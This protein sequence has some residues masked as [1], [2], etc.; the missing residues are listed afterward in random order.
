MDRCEICKNWVVGYSYENGSYEGKPKFWDGI[1][2]NCG[3]LDENRI[4]NCGEMVE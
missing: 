2:T 1:C 3:Y 4:R